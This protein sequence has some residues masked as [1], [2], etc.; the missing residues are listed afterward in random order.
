MNKKNKSIIIGLVVLILLF[1]GGIIGKRINEEN[2]VIKKAE[3][4]INNGDKKFRATQIFEWVYRKNIE[5][6]DEITNINKESIIDY[7]VG[8]KLHKNILD[9][10]KKGDIL[11]TLYVNDLNINLTKEDLDIFK[12]RN[13]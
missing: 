12:I 6:F 1:I 11:A 13:N 8:I 2:A 4:A 7:T 3:V 9:Q 5:S 10:V